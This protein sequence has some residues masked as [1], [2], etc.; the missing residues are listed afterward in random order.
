MRAQYI[1]LTKIVENN[2]SHKFA[3]NRIICTFE[4]WQNDSLFLVL[5]LRFY[6]KAMI[7]NNYFD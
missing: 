6:I 3:K 7:F 4:T 5:F 2:S 1:V